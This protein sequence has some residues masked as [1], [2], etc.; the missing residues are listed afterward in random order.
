MTTVTA[1]RTPTVK[2]T[3]IERGCTPSR[4]ETLQ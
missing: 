4:E 1:V 3:A 2:H